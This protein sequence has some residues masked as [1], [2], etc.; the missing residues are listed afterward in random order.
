MRDKNCNRRKAL[1]EELVDD[2]DKMN[3]ATK[4]LVYV[5]MILFI[6][7][8]FITI[9]SLGNVG[10]L[11]SIEVIFRSSLASVFGFILSSN[12]KTSKIEKSSI[13]NNIMRNECEEEII[14]HN[15]KEGNI[16]QI[17]IALTICIVSIITILI[18]YA[19]NI[20]HNIA[21]ISQLRDL[22]CSS[23]GFLLGE[24]SIKK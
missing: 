7:S 14:E 15:Y 12:M 24:S 8:I 18:I 2:W 11:K 10:M 21:A 20:T 1:K 19:L 16:I 3:I 23:I 22:M 6:T 17:F 13:Q 4:A 9:Y 5:G